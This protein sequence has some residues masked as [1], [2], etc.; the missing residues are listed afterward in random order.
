MH[1]GAA[2]VKIFAA[3]SLIYRPPN[4]HIPRLIGGVVAGRLTKFVKD[5]GYKS[6]KPK[7]GW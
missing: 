1:L 4:R 2:D 3:R 6:Y 7:Y 5:D